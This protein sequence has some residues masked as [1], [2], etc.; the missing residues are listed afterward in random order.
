VT[1]NAPVVQALN[2]MIT[3]ELTVINQYFLHSTMCRYWG[4]GKLADTFRDISIDEMKDAEAYAERVLELGGL[5][6]F[7][8]INNFGI[9]ETPTEQLTLTR[10]AEILALETLAAGIATAE[11]Y[12]DFATAQ[13]FRQASLEE[14]AHLDW[15]ETQLRMI[16]RLGEVDYL[17]TQV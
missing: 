16:G 11:E 12:K 1:A 13:M 3:I 6:N 5:P 9:G 17:T 15:A 10:D 4:Y 2:T 14:R 8:R 7:Q